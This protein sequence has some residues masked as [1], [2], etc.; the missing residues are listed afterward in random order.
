MDSYFQL[1]NQPQAYQ[2]SWY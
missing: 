1:T 2:I